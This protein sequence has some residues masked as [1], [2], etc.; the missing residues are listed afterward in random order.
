MKK[1]DLDFTSLLDIMLI[2]L[3]VFLLNSHTETLE[4]EEAGQIQMAE[5]LKK[6][7]ATESENHL[8]IAENSKK[9][10]QLQDLQRQ[11]EHLLKAPRQSAQT[12]HNYQ[13][14]AQKFYFMNIQI[15]APDNQLII[16]EKKHPLFITTEE[17]QSE[18][19][20]IAKRKAIEDILEKEI[21]GKEGGY[22]FIL[23]SAGKDLRIPRLVYTLLWEAVKETEKKYGPD[24]VF[25]TEF[26]IK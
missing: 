14:I 22:Q 4:K 19:M 17:S 5:N 26:Y 25:K 20:R 13:T 24:K 12:W 18:E 23:L 6:I 2:L 1:I 9:Q 7:Q 8:L 3:F 15:T 11:L 16:N 21:D 10:E